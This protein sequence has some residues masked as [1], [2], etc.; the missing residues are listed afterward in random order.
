MS[1]SRRAGEHFEHQRSLMSISRQ[2]DEQV[3]EAGRLRVSGLRFRGLGRMGGWFRVRGLGWRVDSLSASLLSS[4]KIGFCWAVYR[5]EI[6]WLSRSEGSCLA[7]RIACFLGS[8][9]VGFFAG[10]SAGWKM[11]L[12]NLGFRGQ[13]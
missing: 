1:I 3:H 8:L 11:L 9:Q 7:V 10:K 5:S 2:A 6:C 4:L 12:S 13:G